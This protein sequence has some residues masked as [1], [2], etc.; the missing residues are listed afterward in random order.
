MRSGTLVSTQSTPVSTLR[1][2]RFQTAHAERNPCEYSEYPYEYSEY[3]CA[4]TAFLDR[5]CAAESLC[6]LRVTVLVLR[7]PVVSTR[8]TPVSTQSTPVSTLRSMR[9]Q[10]AHAQRNPSEYSEYPCKYTAS[11]VFP[12]RACR[13]E[14]V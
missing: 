9:F 4:F 7:V 12:H 6:V 1:L 10:T 11:I 8:S 3:P 2:M 14:P 13:A 5:A